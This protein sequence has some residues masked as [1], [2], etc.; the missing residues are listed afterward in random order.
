MEM[1]YHVRCPILWNLSQLVPGFFKLPAPLDFDNTHDVLP[2]WKEVQFLVASPVSP[3]IRTNTSRS[4]DDVDGGRSF[5][6]QVRDRSLP[7]ARRRAYHDW[8]CMFLCAACCCS[9]QS[10]MVCCLTQ[11][12]LCVGWCCTEWGRA[13]D[14]L[15]TNTNHVLLSNAN[16]KYENINMKQKST[17]PVGAY[18]LIP[19]HFSVI[20]RR[21]FVKSQNSSQRGKVWMV[22][23][24]CG[25]VWM[26][27][28]FCGNIWIV[29]DLCGNI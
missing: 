8:L 29:M 23:D 5:L 3:T 11:K 24:V 17:R 6:E 20:W 2:R 12:F 4:V 7:I 27:T 26:V 19:H 15:Q 28:Y 21:H 14:M 13:T 25:K 16:K 9:V 18:L 22:I 1:V 10:V